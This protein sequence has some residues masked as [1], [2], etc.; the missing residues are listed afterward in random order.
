MEGETKT[1]RIDQKSTFFIS[2]FFS[3]KI[4]NIRKPKTPIFERGQHKNFLRQVLIIFQRS[5]KQE[6]F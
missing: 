5:Y 3:L 1:P 2:L 4:Q 6:I